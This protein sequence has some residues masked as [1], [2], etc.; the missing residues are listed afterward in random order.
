MIGERLL[1]ARAITEAQLEEA[2]AWQRASGGLLGE[3]LLKL[4]YIT[5]EA[6]ARAL[7]SQ[8]GVPFRAINGVEPDPAAVALLP[9]AIARRYL[10]AAVALE[11]DTLRVVQAN[12]FDVVGL[13]VVQRACG[14]RVETE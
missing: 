2:L 11:H 5:D 7:A 8:A 14:R 13:D 3:I 6:I 9:E 12:P 1:A 4:H 10:V